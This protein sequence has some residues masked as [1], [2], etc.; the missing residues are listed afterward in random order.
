MIKKYIVL[1]AIITVTAYGNQDNITLDQSALAINNKVKYEVWNPPMGKKESAES[2]KD[3]NCIG[4]ICGLK[5]DGKIYKAFTSVR[6]K[7]KKNCKL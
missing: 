6:D 5:K 3:G 4:S 2:C 7:L 1:I